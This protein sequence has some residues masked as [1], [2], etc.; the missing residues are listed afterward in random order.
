MVNQRS[1]KVEKKR[2]VGVLGLFAAIFILLPSLCFSFLLA[3]AS[4]ATINS[5]LMYKQPFQI[6]AFLEGLLLTSFFVVMI[7]IAIKI[8]SYQE[9]A[10]KLFLYICPFYYFLI[11][12]SV[13]FVPNAR[14]YAW[15]I[16]LIGTLTLSLISIFFLIRPKVKEQ[17]R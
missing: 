11:V 10:R 12:S 2:S 13:D 8:K 9:R 16:Y 6:I 3:G 4:I 7:I 1:P 14:S 15:Q 5:T 17:F